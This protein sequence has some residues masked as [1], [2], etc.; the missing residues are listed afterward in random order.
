MLI[1]FFNKLIPILIKI[2]TIPFDFLLFHFN[3]N[4]K[5]KCILKT[6][7]KS[8]L[9][10]GMNVNYRILSTI[11]FLKSHGFT[12]YYLTTNNNFSKNLNDN[13]N[14]IN[15]RNSY[16]AKRVF[17]NN[18]IPF[19]IYFA[20]DPRFC[21]NG[22]EEFKGI[23]FFDN[24]DNY[25]IYYG[26]NCS[27]KFSTK[28]LKA[29]KKCFE[30]ANFILARN[31]EI[32]QALRNYNLKNKIKL[33]IP[34]SCD[35]SRFKKTKNL[36][37]SQIS[38][39]YCGG[40]YGQKET[41]FTHGFDDFTLLYESLSENNLTIHLYPN[42]QQYAI[43]YQSILEISNK[44]IKIY[45]SI[46]N[47]LL[48]EEISKYDFGIIPHYK[49]ENSSINIEKLNFATSNKFINFLEAGIP[50]IVT[51]EMKFMAWIVKRYQIGIVVDKTEFKNLKNIIHSYNYNNLCENVE[52][53]R[54]KFVFNNKY[55][56]LKHI[57]C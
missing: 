29:E 50:I 56:K 31:L 5:K 26:L 14:E 38:L 53:I 48:I 46:R 4:I 41:S 11:K 3:I 27:H 20:S 33:F 35:I 13:I 39:V 9:I 16:H 51:N 52:K 49:T 12:I 47:D 15:I 6:N 57:I 45:K 34:D 17:K 2:S 21:S 10:Y 55:E 7:E 1:Y 23:K 30:N 28:L 24:Y 54:T 36:N 40:L 22:I 43:H 32:N 8:I 18:E 42:P 44:N 19:L 25:I 37:S